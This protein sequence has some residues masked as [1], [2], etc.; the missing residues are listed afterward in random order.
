[1]PRQGEWGAVSHQHLK[2]MHGD[3][4]RLHEQPGLFID[5][6]KIPFTEESW[7]K[8]RDGAMLNCDCVDFMAKT[9]Y[10]ALGTTMPGVDRVGRSELLK[11]SDEASKFTVLGV[12][13]SE[14][15]RW[16]GQAE[17]A[18]L[19]PMLRILVGKDNVSAALHGQL[20]PLNDKSL[21]LLQTN[22]TELHTTMV[23]LA[24][25]VLSGKR[26]TIRNFDTNDA[27]P[28]KVVDDYL[29][30]G[31]RR[32]LKPAGLEKDADLV[33]GQPKFFIQQKDNK[34]CGLM[35]CTHMIRTL[36]G[37]DLDHVYWGVFVDLLRIF[38]DLWLFKQSEFYGAISP[39]NL[40]A[41]P[42]GG[43]KRMLSKKAHVF[44]LN[45]T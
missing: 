35:S 25:P 9:I 14:S 15:L 3:L 11:A 29:M 28:K 45:L 41:V 42:P 36:T 40:G 44:A 22:T 23:E 7:L 27:R 18:D 17:E 2:L 8:F 13:H 4:A 10:Q 6:G 16:L 37:E 30:T 20:D 32:L 5:K 19:R 31:I 24:R 39:G 33:R 26:W 43:G 12:L 34:V 1:M 38:F 21:L